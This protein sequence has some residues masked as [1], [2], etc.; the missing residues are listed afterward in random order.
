MT[1]KRGSSGQRAE[2]TLSI[3]REKAKLIHGRVKRHWTSQSKK[4]TAEQ[5]S[6]LLV[7]LQRS[8]VPLKIVLAILAV[9]EQLRM[10]FV[11]VAHFGTQPGHNSIR[12]DLFNAARF[13]ELIRVVNLHQ[14]KRIAT[15][16]DLE[17][18]RESR[19]KKKVHI[20]KL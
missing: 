18:A 10:R 6:L 11:T 16:L 3:R 19:D 12:F 8:S 2:R 5:M 13:S 14:L 20:L 17:A 7:I 15:Y 9:W 1:G 4:Q